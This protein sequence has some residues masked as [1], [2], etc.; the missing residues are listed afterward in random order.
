MSPMKRAFLSALA[1]LAGCATSGGIK[2]T[3][4]PASPPPAAPIEAKEAT[5]DFKIGT[6]EPEGQFDLLATLTPVDFGATS[7]DEL[8]AAIRADV[9]KLGG[10][11]VIGVQNGA[12]A[13]IK[14]SVYRNHRDVTTVPATPPAS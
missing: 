5:C 1:M 12:G 11:T 9:C 3:V 4:A 14:A 10:D 8:R 7:Y 13:Y 2:Y 6:K